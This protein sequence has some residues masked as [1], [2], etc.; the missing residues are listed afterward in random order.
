MA[1]Y[2]HQQHSY[3]TNKHP[4][5][6]WISNYTH[7]IPWILIINRCPIWL[8]QAHIHT[9]T[10]PYTT[11]DLAMKCN[12]CSLGKFSVNIS[13]SIIVFFIH[14]RQVDLTG[15]EAT[16]DKSHD[17]LHRVWHSYYMIW[18]HNKPGLILGL[19]P[20]NERRRYFVT[21]SLIGWAAPCKHCIFIF[22]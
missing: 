10:S 22:I 1:W 6:A 20:A 5:K 19:R 11:A 18:V 12:I 15:I 8:F 3:D 13:Q 21:T 9:Q 7:N 16:V 4:Y 17:A 2:F 14:T